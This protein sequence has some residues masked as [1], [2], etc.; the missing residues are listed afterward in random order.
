MLSL[1]F[2]SNFDCSCKTTQTNNDFNFEHFHYSHFIQDKENDIFGPDHENN[3]DQIFDLNPNFDYYNI[4]DF[5][6]L[7]QNQ[8]TKIK[9]SLSLLHTNISSLM[10]NFDNLEICINDLQCDFDVIALSE[11]WNPKSKKNFRPGILSQ[12]QEYKGT[13]GNSLKSGCGMY[14]KNGVKFLE[15]NDLCLSF[16]DD[17]NEFQSFWIEIVNTNAANIIIGVYYRHPK[18]NSDDTFNTKLKETLG[19]MKNENKMIIITGD[20]N[21]DLLRLNKNEYSKAFIDI[22]FSH[23]LQPCIVEPTRC[24]NGNRPSLIDNIFINV[25][26]K[27][28]K[29]GNLTSKISDHLPNFLLIN[30]LIPK[31]PKTKRQIRNFD[32][33]NKDAFND[34]V[35]RIELLSTDT[36]DINT[37]YNQFHNQFSELIEKHAP[38]KTLSKKD[39]K[40]QQQ[41][42]ISKHIQ[43]EMRIRDIMHKKYLRSKSS[44]WFNRFKLYRNRVKKMIFISKKKYY[45]EYFT[46]HERNSK[47]IWEGIGS[48]IHKKSKKNFDDIFINENGNIN[49]DQKQVSDKFNNYFTTIADNLV[50]K[51]G[52]TNNKYQDYLKNPNEHSFF[53]N[54]IEPDEVLTI[55]TSINPNKSADFVGI[56]PRFVKLSAF[57]M[58]ENLTHIFNIS[59]RSG[60]FPD[61]MKVAKVIPIHKTGSKMELSNYRPISLLPIFSKIFEKLMHSRI[62]QFLQDKNILFKNQYGFQKK[63]S[64]EHAIFDIHSKIVDAYENKEIPCC[65]FLDFAKAFDTVNHRIMLNELSYYGIRGVSNNWLESY[66]SNRQQCVQ[67]GS[68]TSDF[69]PINC[70]VPQGSVLGPLLFL[71]YI[72]DIANTSSILKFQLFADDTCIFLSHKNRSTLETQLNNELSKVSNWLIANKLSL[73]VDKTNVLVFR[74]KN[75]SDEIILDLQINGDKLKEK[76]FAKYLGI[77]FD[78]K[79]TWQYQIEHI[80]SKLVKGNALLAKLRHFLPAQKL[81]PVYNSLVQPHLDYGNLSWSTTA[82]T[83]LKKIEKLQNKAIRIISFKNK[84]DDSSPLYKQHDILPLKLNIKFNQCKIIWNLFHHQL[85]SS[86]AELF[87]NHGVTLCERDSDRNVLKLHNPYQRTSYGID[88][89]FYRGTRSWNLIPDNNRTIITMLRFKRELKNHLINLV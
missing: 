51:L 82:D 89:I 8:P 4:H 42:W 78:N 6:K 29:S 52:N 66:L 76:L 35:S 21:Y 71:I 84:E 62:Y 11:T 10:H 1:T 39:I 14:I 40:W 50:S 57:S 65:I 68:H 28:L 41:P 75:S 24:V 34:D 63:K 20:F 74:N 44:Y 87:V 64:T 15:R 79:L 56:S 17:N 45:T 53:L 54:E 77:I 25:I 59:F 88:F 12:Y 7:I 27:S 67:I 9:H 69:K 86:I 26:E 13:K 58:Y 33:F 47:K 60:M 5:H 43:N 81:K 36:L 61:K 72:N 16:Y 3:V 2:N 85:P 83:H 46:K 48:I 80:S 19:K 38:M 32:N 73:N 70:G 30:D 31:T 37:I 55:L 22:M 23:F 18:K 49:T